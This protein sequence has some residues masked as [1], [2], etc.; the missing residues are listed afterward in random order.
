MVSF[1]FNFEKIIDKISLWCQT[2][3]ILELP[4][5]CETKMGRKKRTRA[6]IVKPFCYYCDRVFEDEFTLIQH[7]KARH[8]N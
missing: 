5:I 1:I 6:S 2:T 7:Q 8:F 4:Q 3:T